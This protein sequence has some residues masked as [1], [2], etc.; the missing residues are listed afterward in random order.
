MISK[1]ENSRL[2]NR[3]RVLSGE[4]LALVR[5]TVAGGKKLEVKAGRTVFLRPKIVVLKSRMP[6]MAA[7]MAILC[8]SAWAQSS[9]TMGRSRAIASR[10]L[11]SPARNRAVSLR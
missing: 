9:L 3:V 10:T 4:E 8:A 11:L 5:A 6:V 7:L 1:P 2:P